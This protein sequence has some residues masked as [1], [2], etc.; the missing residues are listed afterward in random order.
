LNIKIL[1]KLYLADD[2]N[3]VHSAQIG[4]NKNTNDHVEGD[5]GMNDLIVSSMI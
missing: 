3:R 5:A 4:V 1:S 2:N